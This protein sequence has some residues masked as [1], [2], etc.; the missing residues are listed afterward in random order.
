MYAENASAHPS[1]SAK[2]C[3]SSISS[4]QSARSAWLHPWHVHLAAQYAPTWLSHPATNVSESNAPVVN[5]DAMTAGRIHRNCFTFVGFMELSA[6]SCLHTTWPS[7]LGRFCSRRPS[8]RSRTSVAPSMDK[9]RAHNEVRCRLPRTRGGFPS[10][11]QQPCA[12]PR[13]IEPAPS[14]LRAV[15]L[16][17]E[18]LCQARRVCPLSVCPRRVPPFAPERP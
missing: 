3:A 1:C 4:R 7:S 12:I 18:V 9:V 11:N 13:C 14:V 16:P 10:C 15:H 5:I 8:R 6:W 2:R 17:A